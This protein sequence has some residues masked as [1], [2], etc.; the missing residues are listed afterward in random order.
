MVKNTLLYIFIYIFTTG[1]LYNVTC[2]DCYLGVSAPD[3]SVD[4][5]G[6]YHME[7][8]GGYSQTFTTIEAETGYDEHKKIAWM[9]S[10]EVLMGNTWVNL[11][12]PASYTDESGVA[13]AVLGVWPDFIGDTITVWSGYEDNCGILHRDSINVIIQ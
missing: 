10:Q 13:N 6:Y 5:N 8:L 4:S 11:V 9:S 7:M 2:L 12:N 1:C 3:L